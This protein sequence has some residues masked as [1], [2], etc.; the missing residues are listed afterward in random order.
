MI[1]RTSKTTLRMCKKYSL[2]F[3][4]NIENRFNL[5]TALGIPLRLCFYVS[6]LLFLLSFPQLAG[7]VKIYR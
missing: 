1:N 6:L 3:K 5:E 2:V 7:N 4:F